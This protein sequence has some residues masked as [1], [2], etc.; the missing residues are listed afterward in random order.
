MGVADPCA[1]RCAAVHQAFGKAHIDAPEGNFCDR[2]NRLG[3]TPARVGKDETPEAVR[4]RQRLV[5]Q[6]LRY[7]QRFGFLFRYALGRIAPL[8]GQAGCGGNAGLPFADTLQHHLT[9]SRGEQPHAQASADHQ[10]IIVTG[11][12]RMEHHLPGRQ[13]CALHPAPQ[14]AHHR[15]AAGKPLLYRTC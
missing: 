12:A 1:V 2:L 5:K 7:A 3:Q 9:A 15:I 13:A 4:V 11:I 14:L 10:Q 8:T 6:A